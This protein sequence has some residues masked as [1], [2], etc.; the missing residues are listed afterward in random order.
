MSVVVIPI[1][2]PNEN[3]ALLAGFLGGLAFVAV[4]FALEH[5]ITVRRRA[6]ESAISRTEYHGRPTAA[7]AEACATVSS[8]TE[9]AGE[10]EPSPA[11]TQK[12]ILYA[13]GAAYRLP[14]PPP[15]SRP[16]P[17]MRPVFTDQQVPSTA[18]LEPSPQRRAEAVS[19]RASASSYSLRLAEQ[20]RGLAPAQDDV[21]WSER[22]DEAEDQRPTAMASGAGVL[23]IPSLE[24]PFHTLND[25]HRRSSFSSVKAASS[26]PVEDQPPPLQPS[27]SPSVFSTWAAHPTLARSAT[28]EVL[29]FP[30]LQRSSRSLFRHPSSPTVGGA[31]Q[32]QSV[33]VQQ[34]DK[35]GANSEAEE[36][37]ED[38][39]APPAG[40]PPP[41]SH[42]L[43]AL[44]ATP[45]TAVGSDVVTAA[46]TDPVR[47]GGGEDVEEQQHQQLQSIQNGVE[48][49]PRR[50]SRGSVAVD[51]VVAVIAPRRPIEREERTAY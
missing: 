13:S 5:C 3:Y 27:P 6:R 48:T 41:S 4:Y 19:G 17:S 18:M 44:S 15:S 11:P 45:A 12:P 42:L 35:D 32:R 26:S 10:A 7:A 40:P 9:R 29:Q 2:V 34:A 16:Q 22:T 43:H 36:E 39:V 47:G 25:P 49:S 14:R 24:A 46:A 33:S 50:Y 20:G 28:G 8:H 23:R 1:N 37:E 31:Q 38:A 51:D 21:D 30:P